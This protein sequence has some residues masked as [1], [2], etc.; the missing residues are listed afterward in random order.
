MSLPSSL[1][2]M[3]QWEGLFLQWSDL[4]C[5]GTYTVCQFSLQQERPLPPETLY[6]IKPA[7]T[8][9]WFM[10][11]QIIPHSSHFTNHICFNFFFFVVVWLGLPPASNKDCLVGAFPMQLFFSNWVRKCIFHSRSS[12]DALLWTATLQ[13][14]P[15]STTRGSFYWGFMGN[16]G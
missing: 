4:C 13:E 2:C 9:M 6:G 5:T 11:Q 12:W 1:L 10:G 7:P 14:C 15:L 3:C 16:G 8:L